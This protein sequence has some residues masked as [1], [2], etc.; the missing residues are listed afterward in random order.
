MRQVTATLESITPYFQSR[1]ISVPKKDRENPRDYEERTWQERIHADD[2]GRVYIPS[3]AF[4]KSLIRAAQMRSQQIPG[5]GKAT[6]TKHFMAGLFVP[7]NLTLSITKDDVQPMT[8]LLNSDGKRGGGTRVERKMP[9]IPQWSGD[10]TFYVLDDTITKQVFEEHLADAGLI[11]GIGQ[12]RPENGGFCGR[13]KV[14][15]CKWAEK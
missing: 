8:L 1:Y 9:R 4:Q 14:V 13:F 5:K 3:T 11:V 10:V 2:A 12:N 7:E 15:G 6:Y